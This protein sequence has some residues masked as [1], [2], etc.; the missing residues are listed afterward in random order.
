MREFT[1][2]PDFAKQLAASVDAVASR[3]AE[4][5]A[6]ELRKNVSA[7]ARTGIHYPWMPRRSSAPGEF[8]QEQSGSLLDSVGVANPRFHPGL[9]EFEYAVGF[10]GEDMEKLQQLEFTGPGRRAPLTMTVMSAAT[11]EAM[12]EGLRD[13]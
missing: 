2:N 1:P 5:S 3:A 10:F 9:Q 8:P 7:G 6:D 13:A 4:A 11:Y 12:A